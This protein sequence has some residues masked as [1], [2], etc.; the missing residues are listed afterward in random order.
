MFG[1][2]DVFILDINSIF[3]AIKGTQGQEVEGLPQHS[4][5]KLT[6]YL[7]LN[8]CAIIWAILI[9]RILIVRAQFRCLQEGLVLRATVLLRVLSS[10]AL[11]IQLFECIL[12]EDQ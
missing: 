8:E 12:Y 6:L 5:N 9:A 4:S 2:V 10:L 3:R 1:A 7:G 11:K